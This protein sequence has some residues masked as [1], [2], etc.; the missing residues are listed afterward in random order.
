MGNF[1]VWLKGLAAAVAGGAIA[2]A[3]QAVST[4][5]TTGPQIKTA[6]IAGAGLT[7]AAYLTDSPVKK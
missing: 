4:G 5:D 1:V 7:V 2:A 3:A 6:A